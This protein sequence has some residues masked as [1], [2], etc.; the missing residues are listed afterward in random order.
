MGV[1]KGGGGTE[2]DKDGEGTERDKDG[3]GTERDKD[4]EGHREGGARSVLS[5]QHT[6]NVVDQ[7]DNHLS[8]GRVWSKVKREWGTDNAAR[9][10]VAVVRLRA[11]GH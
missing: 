4:G 5:P 3:G 6:F 7:H 11:T 9:A 10:G 1:D 2:R 8:S